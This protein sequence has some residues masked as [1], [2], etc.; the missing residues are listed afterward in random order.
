ME[1]FPSS[2]DTLSNLNASPTTLLTPDP[3]TTSVASL[4]HSM[5]ASASLVVIDST[6]E[7]YQDLVAGVRAGAEVVVLN[8]VQDAIAQIT[9]ALTGRTG[10][11]SLHIVSR[12]F[13][14]GLQIGNTR[15]DNTTLGQYTNQLASWKT[16]LSATA[17]IVIYGSGVANDPL[18]TQ[19]P[20]PFT[21]TPF[22]VKFAQLTG[23]DL[24]ASTDI[25]GHPSLD[26]DWDFE[27]TFG[28]VE[29]PIAFEPATLATYHS[30]LSLTITP[31]D[32]TLSYAND[33]PG[34]AIQVASGNANSSSAPTALPLNLSI[35]EL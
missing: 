12:G 15:L 27:Y 23:A 31:T 6:L 5:T 16:A 1:L 18:L 25:T 32:E 26:G 28:Q 30:T 14:T 13:S 8:P 35:E 34:I 20:T 4:P 17:D 2:A 9:Q 7:N 21:P 3:L 29:S 19:R 22:L 33:A 24:A 10:I 11:E